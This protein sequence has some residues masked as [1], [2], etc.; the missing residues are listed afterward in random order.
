MNR[1]YRCSIKYNS[2]CTPLKK[3]V[4][5]TNLDTIGCKCP[6]KLDYRLNPFFFAILSIA[7]MSMVACTSQSTSSPPESTTTAALGTYPRP[8]LQYPG[9]NLRFERIS[10]E[11]GL[12]HS[13]VYCIFQDSKGF[14]WFGTRDGL[15]KYDGYTFTVYKHDPTDPHSLSH[16]QVMTI[17]EDSNGIL[18]VG[19]KSGMS[20][21]RLVVHLFIRDYYE[22]DFW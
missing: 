14:M 19:S 22:I 13:T 15:N 8:V 5:F 10:I 2:R 17:F 3:L 21:R 6:M 16:N 4:S 11:Q 7:I 12:S 1:N 9:Q 20:P 18:W